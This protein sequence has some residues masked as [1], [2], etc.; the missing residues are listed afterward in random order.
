VE[1]FF[2]STTM[3]LVEEMVKRDEACKQQ[4][5]WFTGFN[6]A[7][8][9]RYEWATGAANK[10]CGSNNEWTNE[11]SQLFRDITDHRLKHTV[12]GSRKAVVVSTSSGMVGQLNGLLLSTA[13]GVA[14]DAAGYSTWDFWDLFHNPKFALHQERILADPALAKLKHTDPTNLFGALSLGSAKKHETKE[15][16]VQE[17]KTTLSTDLQPKAD[18]LCGLLANDG[19]LR[20]PLLQKLALRDAGLWQETRHAITLKALAGKTTQDREKFLA[21]TLGQL[22]YQFK[23]PALSP[24]EHTK[25]VFFRHPGTCTLAESCMLRAMVG[26]PSAKLQNVVEE[27]QDEFSRCDTVIVGIHVRLGAAFGMKKEINSD[28]DAAVQ[29]KQNA[30]TKM[31]ELQWILENSHRDM[32]AQESKRRKGTLKR[33]AEAKL[34]IKQAQAYNMDYRMPKVLLIPLTRQQRYEQIVAARSLCI[35]PVCT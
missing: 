13:V 15:S 20:G 26:T 29:E 3:S 17:V 9:W 10:F 24:Y 28:L 25:G 4:R 27:H 7:K 23:S 35:Q 21:S 32:T 16:F 6:K 2:H 12:L 33:E 18:G 19:G 14:S 30:R 11:Y 22:M 31:D 8:W 34:K 5:S 1:K